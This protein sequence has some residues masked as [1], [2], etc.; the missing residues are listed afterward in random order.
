M[1]AMPGRALLTHPMLADGALAVAMTVT[2]LLLGLETPVAQ[3]KPFDAWAVLLIVAVTFPLAL[4]RLAPGAV[5]LWGHTVWFVYVSLDYWPLVLAY[6]MLVVFYTVAAVGA[7]WT[8]PT[9]VALG[10]LIWIY[11]GWVTPGSSM[12]SVIGQ[13]I[14]IPLV[15]WW[16]GHGARQLEVTNRRLADATEELRQGQTDLA[17]RVLV[18]ERVRI[19]RELHDVVAHHMSVISVQAGLARY[20]LRS[21]PDTAHGALDAVL[22]TSTEALDELRRML[23]LLRLGREADEADA[24]QPLPGLEG[25][26]DLATRVSGAGLPV[27]LTVSGTARPL[28]QGIALTAYRIVQ[29]SLTNALKHAGPATATVLVRFEAEALTITVTDDGPGQPSSSGS[30]HGLVGLRERAALYSGSL[31]AGP[32]GTHGFR[33]SARLPYP[34]P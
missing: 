1:Q 2:S 10:A 4:R 21:D 3:W 31:D 24:R 7:R 8:A 34:Q 20:V 19:A 16:I 17:R 29:E 6:P 11:G 14:A 27:V 22:T 33:V 32:Q 28:P 12:A 26:P 9:G 25:L 5:M 30:G 15:V 18:D 13:G 23:G